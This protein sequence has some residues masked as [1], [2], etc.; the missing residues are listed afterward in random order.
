[1]RHARDGAFSDVDI[2]PNVGNFPCLMLTDGQSPITVPPSTAHDGA[3]MGDEMGTKLQTIVQDV[4]RS[5]AKVAAEGEFYRS[6]VTAAQKAEACEQS[7]ETFVAVG[8][9]LN[10]LLERMVREHNR[11]LQVFSASDL[12]V[13]G[14]LLSDTI[15]D[16]VVDP[17]RDAAEKFRDEAAEVDVD[18]I[19]DFRM[20]REVA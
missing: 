19:R 5:L 1:M 20:A 3:P 14:K 16:Y 18:A 4:S 12:K 13:I 10:I 6:P 2:Q 11:D 15:K 7:V 9:D 8:E 17:L